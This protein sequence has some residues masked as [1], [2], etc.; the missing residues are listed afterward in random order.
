MIEAEPSDLLFG[1]HSQKLEQV[2]ISMTDLLSQK[3]SYQA[4]QP[5][6]Q[7]MEFS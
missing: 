3:Y 4:Q 6:S 1:E 2:V 7:Q 5:E